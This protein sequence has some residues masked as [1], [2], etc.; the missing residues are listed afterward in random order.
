M[1][2]HLRMAASLTKV[3]IGPETGTPWRVWDGGSALAVA[4]FGE[5]GGVAATDLSQATVGIWD[6]AVVVPVE[7]GFV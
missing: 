7:D 2:V 6:G 1:P 5:W 4:S 3:L